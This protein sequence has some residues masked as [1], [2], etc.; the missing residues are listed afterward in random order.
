MTTPIVAAARAVD[1][2][3]GANIA[4]LRSTTSIQIH[5]ATCR[6]RRQQLLCSACRELAERCAEL[7]ERA[8]RLAARVE[9]IAEAA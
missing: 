9:R 2:L 4:L 3:R 1:R 6:A 5:H 7:A 8:T